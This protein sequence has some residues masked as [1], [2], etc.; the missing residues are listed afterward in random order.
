[1]MSRVSDFVGDQVIAK[2][3]KFSSFNEEGVAFV[4]ACCFEVEEA[5]DMWFPEDS[6]HFDPSLLL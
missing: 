3:T 2:F 5:V 6:I 1:M 4:I